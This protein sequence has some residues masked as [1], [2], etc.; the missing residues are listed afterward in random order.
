MANFQRPSLT[1]F[2][3]TWKHTENDRIILFCS[4]NKLLSRH[5]LSIYKLAEKLSL[6]VV[7][8]F[9]LI[10]FYT[11]LHHTVFFCDQRYKHTQNVYFLKKKRINK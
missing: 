2:S 6:K 4:D 8:I 1:Q 9:I 5:T 11:L 7:F 10:N 3:L